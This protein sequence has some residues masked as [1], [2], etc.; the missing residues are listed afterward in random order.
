MDIELKF[1]IARKEEVYENPE[2]THL[3]CEIPAQIVKRVMNSVIP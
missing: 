2:F 3:I 1:V